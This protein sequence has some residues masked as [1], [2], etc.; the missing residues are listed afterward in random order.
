[1]PNPGTGR[2]VRF[3]EHRLL[4]TDQ[5]VLDDRAFQRPSGRREPEQSTLTQNGRQLRLSVGGVAEEQHGRV[6]GHAGQD[7]QCAHELLCADRD[8]YQ[9]EAVV[10][11]RLADR[12]H[13]QHGT[14]PGLRILQDQPVG[15]QV[16]QTGTA[17]KEDH[18]VPGL[19]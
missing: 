7:R 2:A 5:H 13:P 4:L 10:R 15:L 18:V 3:A 9:V 16:D 19:Q 1:M 17:G 14:V 11:H 8:E 12:G 6:V